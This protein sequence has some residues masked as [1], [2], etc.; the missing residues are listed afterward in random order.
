[1]TLCD[2]GVVLALGLRHHPRVTNSPVLVA[3]DLTADAEPALLRGRAHAEAVGVPWVVCHVIPDVLRHH[4]LVPTREENDLTL[5]GELT[6]QAAD[7]VTEQ[8]RRVLGAS[9]DDW[10]IIVETGTPEDEIVRIAEAERASLVVIGARP[11]EGAERILGHVAE[12]VVR[13]VHTSVLVARRGGSHSGKIVVATDFTEASMPC[14]R[15]GAMLIAK[16]GVDATLLHVMQIPSRVGSALGSVATA[17]GSPWMP[18]STATLAQLEALGR[19]TLDGLA[20]EHGFARSEQVE[21]DPA[22]VI[23]TRASAMT[24]EMIVMGGRGRS[25]LSRLMLGSTAEKVI[26]KSD[27]SVLIVR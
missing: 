20:K 13:Y 2:A 15:F 23:I 26:R 5:A 6:K 3:T 1:L 21:G 4:P 16:A 27:T 9:P 19:V 7:L 17:L 24:A 22:E 12:R 8:V 18:P 11:R 14:V 10:R 25:G